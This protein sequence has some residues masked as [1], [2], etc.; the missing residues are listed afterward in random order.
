M[1]STS[2]SASSE[3]VTDPVAHRG[4]AGERFGKRV[5]ALETSFTESRAVQ[6]FVRGGA[7]NAAKI[8]KDS[9]TWGFGDYEENVR[10]VQWMRDYNERAGEQRKLRFYGIDLSGADNDAAFPNA[11][12][13][14]RSVV[15]F[16]R[17]TTPSSKSDYDWA[18]T[19]SWF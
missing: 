2:S 9:L 8:A 17:E 4:A 10:L 11:D 6:D 19:T 15:G 5:L 13:A 7:G 3:C 16:L 14:V 12:V 18:C 1:V